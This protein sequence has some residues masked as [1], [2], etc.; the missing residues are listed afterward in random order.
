MAV[1]LLAVNRQRGERLFLDLLER[2]VP[3]GA[4]AFPTQ[5]PSDLHLLTPE[6]VAERET[7]VNPIY[8]SVFSMPVVMEATISTKGSGK[9]AFGGARIGVSDFR[10]VWE[11]DN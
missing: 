10:Q 8:K 5:E 7:F 3:E 11:A 4:S 9:S 1:S 6:E 2:S